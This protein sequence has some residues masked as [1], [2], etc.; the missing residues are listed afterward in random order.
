MSIENIDQSEV[1]EH[2]LD[3]ARGGTVSSDIFSGL[4]ASLGAPP[5]T[6]VKTSDKQ[7]AAV[8]AFIK[9]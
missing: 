6:R 4:N 9:G 5:V 3:A 7:Q 8:M 1:N 2:E